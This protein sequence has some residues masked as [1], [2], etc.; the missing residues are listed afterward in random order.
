[1]EEKTKLPALLLRRHRRLFGRVGLTQAELAKRAHVSRGCI[2]RL[3]R[4]DELSAEMR[5]FL[6]IAITLNVRIGDMFSE[7]YIAN[8]RDRVD[9]A[10][11]A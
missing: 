5:A 3:E 9:H 10:T 6:R 7:S 11:R 2:Q 1:M 4:V 8:I